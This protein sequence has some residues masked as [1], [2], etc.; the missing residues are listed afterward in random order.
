MRESDCSKWCFEEEVIEAE[1]RERRKS[2]GEI[3]KSRAK[4]GEKRCREMKDEGFQGRGKAVRQSAGL[5][6][7]GGEE[8]EQKDNPDWAAGRDDGWAANRKT[9]VEG[10]EMEIKKVS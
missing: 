2:D 3:V 5:D 8:K 10:G 9:K 1:D 7:S 4:A 6:G